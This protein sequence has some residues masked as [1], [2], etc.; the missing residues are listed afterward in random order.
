MRSAPMLRRC[1]WFCG[2]VSARGSGGAGGG[3]KWVGRTYP[4]SI[5]TIMRSSSGAASAGLGFGL[6]ALWPKARP[7][8]LERSEA[9]IVEGGEGRRRGGGRKLA[10]D[11]GEGADDIFLPSFLPFFLPSYLCICTRRGCGFVLTGRLKPATLKPG[12]LCRS[13]LYILGRMQVSSTCTLE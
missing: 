9:V 11:S 2:W 8:R 1:G 3:G 4:K 5:P 12:A 10:K 13:V 6:L 7:W